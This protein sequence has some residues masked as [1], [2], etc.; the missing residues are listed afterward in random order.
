[1]PKQGWQDDFG[2]QQRG[3]PVRRRAGPK[4]WGRGRTG[5]GWCMCCRRRRYRW[6]HA[7]MSRPA[8]GALD[9]KQAGA[10]LLVESAHVFPWV[11]RALQPTWAFT[12]IFSR[13]LL[14]FSY[15]VVPCRCCTRAQK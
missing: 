1:M 10:R 8:A 3:S 9:C 2:L 15:T 6:A 7:G 11:A 14:L 4:L 5:G 13:I 12:N